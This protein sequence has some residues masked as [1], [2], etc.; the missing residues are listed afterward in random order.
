MGGNKK[1]IDKKASATYSL[2]CRANDD[3]DDPAA[4]LADERVLARVD[5]RHCCRQRRTGTRMRDLLLSTP[6]PQKRASAGELLED[7]DD[8]TRSLRDD[9]SV[10]TASSSQYT[11]SG[12]LTRA[13]RAELIEVSQQAVHCASRCRRRLTLPA[14]PLHRSPVTLSSWASPTTAMT[15]SSTAASLAPLAAPARPSCLLL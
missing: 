1:F 10:V 4:S 11:R 7:G 12:R 15:T 8:G 6:P 3:G 14:A 5:V 9:R 13:R 2:I